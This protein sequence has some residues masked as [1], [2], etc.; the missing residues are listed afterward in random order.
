MTVGELIAV[1]Q[2][3]EADANAYAEVSAEIWN[4]KR[5]ERLEAE[6]STEDELGEGECPMLV[7]SRD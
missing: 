1:L 5:V 2:T 4:I 6:E 3:Y 7:I